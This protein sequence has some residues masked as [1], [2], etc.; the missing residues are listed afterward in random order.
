VPGNFWVASR[1]EPGIQ[2]K[3]TAFG[4]ED[5]RRACD[6][7]ASSVVDSNALELHKARKAALAA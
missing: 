2:G 1:Q 5:S 4:P 3:L 7:I 6:V